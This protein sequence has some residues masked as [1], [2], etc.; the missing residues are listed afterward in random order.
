M[1]FNIDGVIGEIDT[2]PGCSQ[3]GVSHSVF[4]PKQFR[5][6][7]R[8]TNANTKRQILAFEELGYDALICTVD[9]ANLS[10]GKIMVSNNWTLL[11][12]FKSRKTGHDVDI[13]F[14]SAITERDIY[15]E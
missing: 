2:L 4:L 9:S 7:G 8:G 6:E 15:V 14:K 3:I 10:Q 11:T 1:R 5:G 13:W 12:S